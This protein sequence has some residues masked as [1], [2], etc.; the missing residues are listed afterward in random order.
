MSF[1]VQSDLLFFDKAH[2]DAKAAQYVSDYEAAD[3]FPH[4]VIDGFLPEMLLDR[5]VD[6][7]PRPGEV[8]WQ[9]YGN[10]RERKLALADVTMM[11]P[12][13]RHVLAEF[14]SA[15]M[16]EFLEALTGIRGLV[17]DPHYVGG[18]LHQTEP[19]G[20]LKIHADFNMHPRL[21]LQ[22]RLNLLLYLNRKWQDEYG[23]H[24]ELWDGNMDHCVKRI[25]PIFNRC[26]IFTTDARSYHG[27]P[28]P[29]ACP[30][31]VTRKSL[32]LYYYT[33]AG[34]SE[35]EAAHTTSFVPR[36]GEG[37]RR[38]NRVQIGAYVQYRLAPPL[39]VDGVKAMRDRWR[40]RRR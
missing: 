20:L 8:A 33:S 15:L 32:A 18:G 31:G 34:W 30:P 36:P 28:D 39:L 24:L 40:G 35:T 9:R 19:E 10:E 11:G 6:E 13:S 23:G 22:R 12:L 29:L 37:W 26:V 17:P 4:V 14:N 2:L 38:L 27:H 25:A 16:V 1:V 7:F 21:R 3:P 5:I